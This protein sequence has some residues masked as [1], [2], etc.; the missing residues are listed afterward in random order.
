[1]VRPIKS[2]LEFDDLCG[3]RFLILVVT[4]KLRLNLENVIDIFIL[5][6]LYMAVNG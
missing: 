1:M 3:T 2:A 5:L 6:G 4:F